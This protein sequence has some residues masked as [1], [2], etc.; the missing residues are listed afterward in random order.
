[1]TQPQPANLKITDLTEDELKDL[2]DAG[3]VVGGA[4]VPAEV[5]EVAPVALVVPEPPPGVKER[6]KTAKKLEASFTHET[7]GPR[8]GD[9][10][11]KTGGADGGAAAQDVAPMN[12]DW[13]GKV[14][15]EP[16]DAEDKQKFL[17]MLLGAPFFTKTYELFGGQIAVT[18]KTRSAVQEDECGRQSYRDEKF[19]GLI[20]PVDSEIVLND[21]IRRVR[22]YQ[23]TAALHSMKTP[24]GVVRTFAPF[25]A[26]TN[27]EEPLIGAIRVAHDELMKELAH[28][29]LMALRAT[30]MKFEFLVAKM[31][32]SAA[33]PDFWK[34]V[35][36]T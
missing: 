21:R 13:A 33:K 36:G 31:T 29:V 4:I 16:V 7:A 10:A 30:H 15:E 18:F 17:A 35:S 9:N 5:K 19:D 1:M 25:D 27:K 20:G 6:L 14:I 24:G 3:R 2:Q 26:N 11:V 32:L 34:A 23:F 8:A 22:D 28:P 12:P